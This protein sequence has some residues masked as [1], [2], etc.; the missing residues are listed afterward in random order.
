MKSMLVTVA[1][2]LAL[3]TVAAHAADDTEALITLDKQWGES[4]VKGDKS[5]SEKLLADNVVSVD[6]NGV[7]GKQAVLADI[8]PAPA[9][10]RYEPTAY[11]VTFMNADTAIMTHGTKG[12]AAHY[13]L[14]VWSRKGG[15]WQIVATSMTN[16][17]SA[18]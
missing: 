6:E 4:I 13:S 14:H 3:F 5:V 7:M 17:K 16:A 12:A 11:K 18:K 10:T 8:K 1:T 2:F 9:G 15:T